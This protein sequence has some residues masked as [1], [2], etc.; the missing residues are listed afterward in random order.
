MTRKIIGPDLG[1]LHS[2]QELP[3]GATITGT[4]AMTV[5][6]GTWRFYRPQI[7]ADVPPCQASCPAGVDVRGFISLLRKKRIAEAH[8]CYMTENPFPA[9][10]GELCPHPCEMNCLRSDLDEPVEISAL[11]RFIFTHNPARDDETREPKPI[12]SVDGIAIVGTGIPALASLYFLNSL[13]HGGLLFSVSETALPVTLQQP[14]APDHHPNNL[15]EEELTHL[16]ATNTLFEIREGPVLE[17]FQAFKA[18]LW[19]IDSPPPSTVSRVF[20]LFPREETVAVAIARG[21]R[22]AIETDLFLKGQDIHMV[23]D[24]IALGKGGPLSFSRYLAVTRGEEMEMPKPLDPSRVNIRAFE[25]RG[26]TEPEGRFVDVSAP[27]AYSEERAVQA[28]RR[29]FTCGA[30]TLCGR[31]VAYCPDQSV[32][33]DRDRNQVVFDYDFCKGCGICAFECPRGAIGFIKEEAAW[34]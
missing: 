24:L 26:R 27:G 32:Q 18:V 3:I 1:H 8:R 28:A 14:Q 23:E 12:G 4:G 7:L 34:Q 25:K 9:L 21:K 11:E 31:C 29:C 33:P 5:P 16:L 2:F 20:D 13:G 22:A 15:I 17:T 30:C 10:C 19:G 6:T